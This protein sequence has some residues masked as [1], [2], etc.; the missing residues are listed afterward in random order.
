[1][2]VFAPL[3]SL[4]AGFAMAPTRPSVPAPVRGGVMGGATRKEEEKD[5]DSVSDSNESD[6]EN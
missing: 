4:P 1:M 2:V 5:E 6:K 3:Q